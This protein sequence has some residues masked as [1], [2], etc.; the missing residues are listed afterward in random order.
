MI[1]LD[2]MRKLSLAKEEAIAESDSR[3][4]ELVR[5][6]EASILEL[7]NWH[8]QTPGKNGRSKKLRTSTVSDA[9]AALEK[10]KDVAM[11]KDRDR[12]WMALNNLIIETI[13]L[14]R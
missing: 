14:E 11:K 5:Q 4:D 9:A 13:W 7:V 12:T 8:R 2:F 6:I 10:A 1:Y 3:T